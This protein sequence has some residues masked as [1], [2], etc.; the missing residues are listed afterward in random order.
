L[1]GKLQKSGT[2]LA[3]VA[4]LAEERR[5]KNTPVGE[6]GL[7]HSS[8][9]GWDGERGSYL[10]LQ[11][12]GTKTWRTLEV[13]GGRKGLEWVKTSPLQRSCHVTAH[14]LTGQHS[15]GGISVSYVGWWHVRYSVQGQ[16][17]FFSP[18]RL[19]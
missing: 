4:A 5:H 17:F 19:T 14:S 3:S 10:N 1:L 6:A 9:K 8:R 15:E 12:F 2:S 11:G 16:A 13:W 7:S 18:H